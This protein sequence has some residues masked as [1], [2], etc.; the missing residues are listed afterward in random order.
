[1]VEATVHGLSRGTILSDPNFHVEGHTTAS[2]SE[3]GVELERTEEPVY[4]FVI[5]HPEATI[6]VDTGSHPDAGDGHWPP[7]LYDAFEHV[8]AADHPLDADLADAGYAI[9]DVDAVVA[10]HLHVDHAGGLHH[11]AGTDVPV[12]VH[13][14]ELKFAYY[15]AATDEGSEGYVQADFDHDLD[16]RVIRR[17]R[18]EYFEGIELLHLPGHSPGTLGL[19]VHLERETLLFTSDVA[20][21]PVHLEGV[22]QG[23][24][25]LHDRQAW[26]DSV[27][28]LRDL[29]RRH[30]ATVVYGHDP[31]QREQIVEGWP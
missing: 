18:T 19:L 13:A 26:E 7:E 28:R 14:E 8:D 5:D 16:W 1:M 25:L 23:A 27:A 29:R 2:A 31:D 4:S 24:G 15:S 22:P 12:F 20:E 6:L 11:F 30:D 3:P 21:F 9:E 10:T 17:D